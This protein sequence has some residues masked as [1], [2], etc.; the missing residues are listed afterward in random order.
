MGD[1]SI[2]LHVYDPQITEGATPII[3]EALSL[4]GKE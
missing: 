1:A 2:K 4:L 3:G